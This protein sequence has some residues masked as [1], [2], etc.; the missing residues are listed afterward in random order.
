M[1]VLWLCGNTALYKK[2]DP[3]D[4]GWI[5]S[6]LL[7]IA[8]IK[9]LN[10][11]V[12]FPYKRKEGPSM[13]M[14]VK[15]YPIY[16]GKFQRILKTLNIQCEDDY[17]VESLKKIVDSEKPDLIH[18]WGS[19]MPYGLIAMHTSI[20]T[21]LHIQG[22]INPYRDAYYP[23]GY[24]LFT[25]VKSLGL[26]LKTAFYYL[27]F[28]ERYFRYMSLRERKMI[29]SIHYFLGRTEWDYNVLRILKNDE[30]KYFYCS[31]ALRPSIIEESKW[32]YHESRSEIIITSI[33]SGALYKGQDVILR[34]ANLLRLKGVPFKWN[35]FGISEMKI[36]EN[37]S[38]IKAPEVG[39]FCRGKVD[40]K[41]IVNEL[42]NSDV[43]VHCS[44]IENSPNS[45][46]EAQYIGVPVIACD[47]G[48]MKTLLKDGA[49]ILL[50]TNDAYQIAI[51]IDELKHD[52]QLS[53]MISENE[54]RQASLRHDNKKIVRDLL[55]A[56]NQVIETK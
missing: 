27:L 5:G 44:Y 11:V 12:A 55:Y 51:K 32:I 29:N 13:H 31:E 16:L 6:L 19:E 56:Y 17:W 46:C 1:K 34:T 4:G 7:E 3:K 26:H 48:G 8:K 42:K 15:Y 43:Y 52:K 41:T 10:V 50:P 28:S 35:V 2:T 30:F 9:D 25:I 53:N 54:I 49:G 45:V 39:V 20:P 36:Y 22:I 21:M 24:S 18:C 23:P 37:V 38:G 14:G 47:C 40:S 33:I